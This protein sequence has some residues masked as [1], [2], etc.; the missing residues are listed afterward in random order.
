[1]SEHFSRAKISSAAS[2]NL[3]VERPSMIHR[4]TGYRFGRKHVF[5]RVRISHIY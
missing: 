3:E 1:M 5:H 4:F 2:R